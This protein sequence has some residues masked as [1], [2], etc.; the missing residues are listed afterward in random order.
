M[1]EPKEM[2]K[3]EKLK[4]EL[5]QRAEERD[6]IYDDFKSLREF[7]KAVIEEA[8]EEKAKK[9]K[10]TS[11]ALV[12]DPFYGSQGMKCQ[13]RVILGKGSRKLDG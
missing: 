3:S 13:T 11:Q 6:G 9:E 4:Q 1:V 2:S 8:R 5:L 7:L 12:Y 10:N